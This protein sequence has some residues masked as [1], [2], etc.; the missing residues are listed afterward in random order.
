MA[1]MHSI[2]EKMLL[3]DPTTKIRM[4]I[5]IHCVTSENNCMKTNED[6]H[7]LSA[8]QMFGMDSSFWQYK[9]CADIRSDSLET[10]R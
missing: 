3:S 7:I 4:K 8:V 2:A 6:R 9:V 5:D 1:D 10:R